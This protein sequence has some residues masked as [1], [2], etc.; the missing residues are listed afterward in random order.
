MAFIQNDV[1]INGLG[2]NDFG[3]YGLSV[4]GYGL[5]TF[6]FVWACNGIWNPQYD[7]VSTTWTNC[8]D[9]GTPTIETCVEGE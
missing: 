5:N 6:G 1:T 8:E 4:D 3:L 2:L 9:G 7:V